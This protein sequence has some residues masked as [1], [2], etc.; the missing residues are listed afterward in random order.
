MKDWA[1]YMFDLVEKIVAVVATNGLVIRR[2]IFVCMKSN[3]LLNRT[4]VSD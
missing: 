3:N 1:D 2:K 4:F